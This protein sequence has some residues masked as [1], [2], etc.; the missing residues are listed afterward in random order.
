MDEN[1]VINQEE[2]NEFMEKGWSYPTGGGP[3]D[4]GTATTEENAA[5]GLTV[6][7]RAERKDTITD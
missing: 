1:N 4:L 5:G 6:T 2:L 7:I 3:S